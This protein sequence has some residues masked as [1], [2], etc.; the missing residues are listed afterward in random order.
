MIVLSTYGVVRDMHPIR[1]CN[2]T[3]EELPNIY[4]VEDVVFH[5]LSI[6]I[7]DIEWLENQVIVVGVVRVVGSHGHHRIPCGYMM[8]VD[9]V[10]DGTY[11]KWDY[12]F[13]TVVIW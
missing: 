13:M 4:Y 6:H 12:I 9:K 2:M 8:I 10:L 3:M 5:D 1:T 7:E 11:F